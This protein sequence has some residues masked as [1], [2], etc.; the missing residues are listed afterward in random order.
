MKAHK[1]MIKYVGRDSLDWI[2]SENLENTKGFNLLTKEGQLGFVNMIEEATKIKVENL[3]Y[4][5]LPMKL[6]DLG[7]YPLS[8]YA[9]SNKRRSVG[10]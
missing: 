5:K 3:E 2:I 4:N 9:E 1:I 10:V 7:L 8:I 6:I